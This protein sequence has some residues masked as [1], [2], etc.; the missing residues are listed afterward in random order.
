MRRPYE[1]NRTALHRSFQP[2]SRARRDATV[3][4]SGAGR[5]A[6]GVSTLIPREAGCDVVEGDAVA[7]WVQVS[8]LIPREAG[9][10]RDATGATPTASPGFNPHPARGGMRRR[11]QRGH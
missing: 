6:H 3:D 7:V 4:Q 2:S 10:D 11:I 9:C 5:V 1:H 8:T